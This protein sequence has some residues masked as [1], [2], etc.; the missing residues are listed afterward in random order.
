MQ[1]AGQYGTTDAVHGGLRMRGCGVLHIPTYLRGLWAACE[2]TG[3]AVWHR[4][5]IDLANPELPAPALG[6]VVLAAG[7]GTVEGFPASEL[8]VSLERGQSVEMVA[9]MGREGDPVLPGLIS[10]QYVAPRSNGEVLVGATHEDPEEPLWAPEEVQGHLRDKTAVLCP[11]VWEGAAVQRITCGTRVLP[12]A[13]PRGRLPIAR[14]LPDGESHQRWLFTGLGGRGLIHHGVLGR[15]VA[16]EVLAA[17][18]AGRPGPVDPLGVDYVA[19]WLPDP[20][21][22]GATGQADVAA[23]AACA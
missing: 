1:L 4:G 3:R 17:L 16:Q 23:P 18:A 22:E 9:H 19:L 21:S 15:R 10:G 12:P 20:A 11:A 13:G 8:E 7:A 2:A 6:A 5:A 14:R